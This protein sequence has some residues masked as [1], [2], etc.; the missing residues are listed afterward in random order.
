MNLSKGTFWKIE[1]S[2]N[3]KDQMTAN[4]LLAKGYAFASNGSGNV[5][6]GY[7]YRLDNVKVVSHTHEITTGNKCVC[8]Y[9]CDHSKGF[10]DNGK[11]P[12][13]GKACEHKNLD[14]NYYC[15]DCKQQMGV[16][17]ESPDAK[18]TYIPFGE[19]SLAEAVNTAENDS[20]LTL[21]AD[22]DFNAVL[23]QKTLTLDF[24]FAG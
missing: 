17:I 16:M 10:T 23:D 18:I 7:V 19:N 15:R 3:L 24:L 8:G 13:C 6:D 12:D 14:K 4:E 11:C 5:V 2:D 20:K 22:V 1:L 21:L 9:P